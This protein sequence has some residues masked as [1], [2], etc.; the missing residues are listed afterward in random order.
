MNFLIIIGFGYLF[1][2]FKDITKDISDLNNRFDNL[3]VTID[4]MECSYE[5]KEEC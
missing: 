2:K 4:K 1:L 5:N 3:D